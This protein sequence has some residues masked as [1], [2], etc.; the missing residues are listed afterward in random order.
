MN[1]INNIVRQPQRMES[2]KRHFDLVHASKTKTGDSITISERPLQ[3][4]EVV[5]I[6][7]EE[8]QHC[9]TNEG[10]LSFGFYNV[11]PE[12][13][14]F[15]L[16]FAKHFRCRNKSVTMQRDYLTSKYPINFLVNSFYKIRD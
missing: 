1:M 15:I 5:A 8:A 14:R 6:D 11:Y 13:K 10:E 12:S 3:P 16:L 4:C 7:M 2:R 9:D